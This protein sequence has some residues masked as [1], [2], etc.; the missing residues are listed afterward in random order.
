MLA[1]FSLIA[2]RA[3]ARSSFVDS[4]RIVCISHTTHTIVGAFCKPTFAP[5]QKTHSGS[6]DLVEPASVITRLINHYQRANR[7]AS[8]Y[9]PLERR[10]VNTD[11]SRER[12]KKLYINPR[13]PQGDSYSPR[14]G[15]KD[16]TLAVGSNHYQVPGRNYNQTC[17]GFMLTA[18]TRESNPC[19]T[20]FKR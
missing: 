11:D 10:R 16:C 12:K 13:V 9:T 14:F 5:E 17:C 15:L 6:L 7:R 2:G 19:E 20:P 3:V 8:G 18:A 1:S 4:R